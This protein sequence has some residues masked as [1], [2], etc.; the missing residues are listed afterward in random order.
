MPL[1]GTEDRTPAP[2]EETPAA[3]QE[4]GSEGEFLERLS[5]LLL[6]RLLVRVQGALG[7]CDPQMVPQSRELTL[8]WA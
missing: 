5:S 7:A 4:P 3:A 6:I 8:P 1:E 2:L